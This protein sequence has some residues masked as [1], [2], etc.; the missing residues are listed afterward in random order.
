M[1]EPGRKDWTS[2]TAAA[3]LSESL[4]VELVQVSLNKQA[5]GYSRNPLDPEH[6]ETILLEPLQDFL[7]P[8]LQVGKVKPAT[9][10]E[11]T[12]CCSEKVCKR[13]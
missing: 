1:V 11:K 10:L 6:I 8:G 13:Q 5:A 2:R 12:P 9:R 4:D 7:L 3:T